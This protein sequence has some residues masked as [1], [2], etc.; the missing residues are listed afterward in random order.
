MAEILAATCWSAQT[1]ASIFNRSARCFRNCDIAAGTIRRRMNRI[2]VS[3]RI[4]EAT[5]ISEADTAS[6]FFRV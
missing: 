1:E 3:K 2:P 6:G 5:A 4:G